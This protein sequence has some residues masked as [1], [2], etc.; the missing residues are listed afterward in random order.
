MI[1]LDTHAWIWW[2]SDPSELS[3]RALQAIDDEVEQG[4]IVVSAISC[5]ELV[6][7]ERKGRIELEM[8]PENLVRRSAALPFLRYIPISPE[9]A[10]RSNRLPGE[11]HEDPADRFIVATAMIESAPLVTRDRKIRDYP[12]VETT[13]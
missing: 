5:W 8:T 1:L 2:L 12:H 4:E 3:E 9:I 13:W 10:L 11:F 7:L 6:L